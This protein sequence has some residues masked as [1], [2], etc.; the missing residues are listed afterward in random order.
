MTSEHGPFS[1]GMTFRPATVDDA[2]GI[3][4]LQAAIAL[5][6]IGEIDVDLE[7]VIEDLTE[8]RL[9]LEHDSRL[10]IAADGQIVGF[11]L[12]DLSVPQNVWGDVYVHPALPD[13]QRTAVYE[14][15]T[16]WMV[17][18]ANVAVSR[19]PD[20]QEVVLTA[21]AYHADTEHQRHLQACL[22][23]HVRSSYQMWIDLDQPI[24]VPSV[25]A[26]VTVRTA[27]RDEDW[28]RIF[29]AR[30]EAWLDHYGYVLRDYD[31]DYADWRHYWEQNFHD[32]YWF[33]AEA[34][35]EVVAL[36]LCEPTF[37][38]NDQHGYVATLGVRR[39][40]RKQ[41]LGQALLMHSFAGLRQH[42]KTAVALY[43]DGSS[44]TNAVALYQRAGMRIKQQYERFERVLRQGVNQRVTG[45]S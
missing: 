10:I 40:Y 3:L 14:H 26:G 32:G 12:C 37:S 7:E 28:R 41:G 23:E 1:F 17:H 16:G 30:R 38:G 20:D 13:T 11:A 15:L 29:D 31:E 36:S 6:Q 9:E 5:A 8:P 39:A 45:V 19:V 42:G 44:L 4:A 21:F 18:R 35:G 2:P 25:P 22:M 27:T 33:I 34:A 43:V 24:A